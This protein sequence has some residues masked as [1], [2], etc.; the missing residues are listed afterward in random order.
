M[1]LSE[2]DDKVAGLCFS[3]PTLSGDIAYIVVL[4]LTIFI[5]LLIIAALVILSINFHNPALKVA[6]VPEMIV[7]SSLLMIKLWF[8]V[9]LLM[10]PEAWRPICHFKHTS[11]A[12]GALG[13]S[14]LLF[15][16]L[17]R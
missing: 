17:V 3:P 11:Y 10:D 8:S 5:T 14:S 15:F 9:F 7:F 12:L 6:G 4:V 16:R 1:A 13:T 2:R